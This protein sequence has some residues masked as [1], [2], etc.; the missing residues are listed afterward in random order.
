MVMCWTAASA[1]GRETDFSHVADVE[2]AHAG[3]HGHVLGDEPSAGPGYSTGISSRRS[4]P[5]LPSAS[6]GGVESGLLKRAAMG[7]S[8]PE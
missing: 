7:K 8:E 1:P 6:G 4:P 5:S 2:E 3:S